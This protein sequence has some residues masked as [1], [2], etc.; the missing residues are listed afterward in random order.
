M[1][2]PLIICIFMEGKQ[3]LKVRC[4]RYIAS[5]CLSLDRT[6]YTHPD[7][8]GDT[9]NKHSTSISEWPSQQLSLSHQFLV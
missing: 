3:T 7:H 8:R 6:S 2:C 4:P 5:K 9:V 1:P